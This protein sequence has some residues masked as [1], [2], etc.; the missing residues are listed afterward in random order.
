MRFPSANEQKTW[1]QVILTSDYDWDPRILDFELSNS[2]EWNLSLGNQIPSL[3][4][5]SFDEYGDYHK[6]TVANHFSQDLLSNPKGS[7]D[8]DGVINHCVMST[9]A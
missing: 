4:S 5:S 1:P 7:N 3:P 2:S 9:I 6:I 8:L